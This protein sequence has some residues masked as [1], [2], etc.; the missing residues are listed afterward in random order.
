MTE[1]SRELR[2]PIEGGGGAK[3]DIVLES[4]PSQIR[5]GRLSRKPREVGE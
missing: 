4:W 3:K 1:H 5:R 2:L